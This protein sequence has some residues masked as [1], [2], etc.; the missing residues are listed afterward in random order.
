MLTA[1]GSHR[2]TGARRPGKRALVPWLCLLAICLLLPGSR[3]RGQQQPAISVEVKVINVLA[4]VRDKRGQI[5]SNLEKDDFTLDE[6]GRPQTIKYFS[7][8]NDLPLT[9]GLLIDTSL[10]QRRVLNQERTASHSFLTHML[11]EDKDLA[12]VIHFDREVEL[13]QDLT[14]SRDKL[15]RALD[16]VEEPQFSSQSGNRGGSRTGGGGRGDSRPRYGG[17]SGTALYDA[18]FLASDEV[19]KKQQ[20]RKAL[21]LLT[22]GVDHG[23]KESLANAIR[24]AQ[25]AD[26]IV[27]SILF[28]D[29]QQSQGPFGS[30]DPRVIRRA[31]GSR[32]PQQ[33][34]SL[35]GKKVLERIS[36]ETGGRVFEVSKKQPIG[37]I[38]NTI[39]E[40]LR[41]QYSIGYTPA[42]TDAG[43]GY[44]KIHLV[45]RKKDLIVQ[46]R[47][48][49]YADQ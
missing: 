43:G 4:T 33:P 16:L 27:Y 39:E 19:I 14:S 3:L 40:E 29:Q 34:Q 2:R 23:S 32:E 6:D 13:L 17:G 11:R 26:T 37:E 45:T 15:E 7:R 5:V 31:V 38:F 9:L 36:S 24:T 48:G 28:T 35:N 46:A 42:Q 10:S 18:V 25:R 22:D 1:T 44:R 47:D 49:Y 21:I 30:T 8:E 12:F 41:N 20:G